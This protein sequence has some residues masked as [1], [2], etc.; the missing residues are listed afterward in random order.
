MNKNQRKKSKGQSLVEYGLILALVS[1][2]AITV[3]QTMGGE[4]QK[5]MKNVTNR[6]Q[7]ANDLAQASWANDN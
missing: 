4:I 2:V 6:V 7:N 5:T 1:V 3:L